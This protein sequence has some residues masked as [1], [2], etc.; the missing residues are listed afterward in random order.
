MTPGAL[1]L[2]AWVALQPAATA[3]VVL[4]PG[5]V[6]T[7]A[8]DATQQS[9]YEVAL[10]A[11]Q[12]VRV[13]VTQVGLDVALEIVGPDGTTS[14]VI[15]DARTREARE[16]LTWVTT[17]TGVYRLQI[18]A[19]Q[20]PPDGRFLLRVHPPRPEG[21]LDA[22]LLE[23]Q[24]LFR[25]GVRE[26][27]RTET[28]ARERAR[29]AL[30]R[31]ARVWHQVGAPADEARALVAAGLLE[32]PV[33]AVAAIDTCLTAAAAASELDDLHLEIDALSCVAEAS[34]AA[35][36]YDDAVEVHE[37]ALEQALEVGN[38]YRESEALQNL[39]VYHAMLSQTDRARVLYRQAAEVSRAIGDEEVLAFSLA[40]LGALLND[41]GELQEANDVIR[42]A[43]AV[44]GSVAG[45]ALEHVLITLSF[46]LILLG[47]LD[48]AQA[49][50]E[51]GLRIA[52][53]SGNRL[54]SAYLL[55]R[56]AVI[57]GDRG[58]TA[59]ATTHALQALRAARE[60][61]L[62]REE[63]LALDNLGVAH[64]K[65]G[66]FREAAE[67]LT[68]AIAVE[69][70][71]GRPP[72][73]QTLMGLCR[74]HEAA[75]EL[76]A[77]SER[78]RQSLE[79][80]R[81]SG[82]QRYEALATY[83]LARVRRRQG[84]EADAE[85][86]TAEAIRLMEGSRSRLRRQ[87]WRETLVSSHREIDDFYVDLQIEAALRDG[88]RAADA[89]DA[90]ERARARALR[91]ALAESRRARGEAAGGE[92][93]TRAKELRYRVAR[94]EEAT[95]RGKPGGQRGSAIEEELRDI[96][97]DVRRQDSPRE[98][99]VAPPTSADLQSLLDADTTVLAF[100]LNDARGAMWVVTRDTLEMHLLPG[101]ERVRTLARALTAA[102]SRPGGD[103]R[104]SQR[105]LKRLIVSPALPRL[106][107][108]ILVIPD[109]P[110]HDISFAALP[111]PRGGVLLDRHQLV[112][113]PSAAA[114]AFLR[115]PPTREA[116]R[117][118]AV[119]ADPVFRPDDER[120]PGSVAAP[121]GTARA[122]ER[123]ARAAGGLQSLARLPFTRREA[124]GIAALTGGRDALIALDFDASLNTARDAGLQQYRFLHF[125]T[126]GFLN[127]QRP[128]LSGMVLSLY[129]AKG[130]PQ[131]GFLSAWDVLDLELSAEMVVLSGC[132]TASGREV[133]GEGPVGLAQAFMHAGARRVVSTLWNVD[134]LATA[135][136]MQRFYERLLDPQPL[137]PAAALQAAQ[138]DLRSQPR[139][140]H[141][142]YWAAFQLQ[143]D[144]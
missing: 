31:A 40:S 14:G 16:S 125:A 37:L 53:A 9:A 109:G 22:R 87:D 127:A 7:G 24:A 43:V 57:A 19:R 111:D 136:L 99:T 72:A 123:A 49:A 92:R 33:N 30:T 90:A 132:R 82:M 34:F 144:W 32:W 26:R 5:Q 85:R 89:F 55:L 67:A 108:R 44:Q 91:E 88:R 54:A 76:E 60:G 36:R 39:A 86:L 83:L 41:S 58:D 120:L 69:E 131:D 52:R 96:E 133:P 115:Q 70:R 18:R 102:L 139:W 42:E 61:N 2:G 107:S 79:S 142:Y 135:T 124:A 97:A 47:D 68:G 13:D 98:R 48:E 137:A 129:D 8:L 21:P 94:Q 121:N 62:A 38:R 77:A 17:R 65:A 80:I 15:D 73:S 3:P 110:L 71:M 45:H 23:A 84:S 122:V 74:V 27:A 118:V 1:L 50:A 106:R 12:M 81:A 101:R 93:A 128:D 126:H 59:T 117:T 95:L 28:G 78:C 4:L 116:T 46:N 10:D 130:R 112:A 141:P 75:G 56:L 20:V 100:A 35:A 119:I 104:A 29:T 66:A 6:V 134:D 138:L 105:E 25:E 51:K 113:L 63:R 140:R 64:F 114:L 143:G 11:R 103:A